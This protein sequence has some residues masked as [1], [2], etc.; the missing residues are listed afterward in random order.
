VPGSPPGAIER[1]RARRL[2]GVARAGAGAQGRL[3]GPAVNRCETEAAR[4]LLMTLGMSWS[5]RTQHAVTRRSAALR[6]EFHE[7]FAVSDLLEPFELAAL[8]RMLG[9][10]DEVRKQVLELLRE[11][12]VDV[13]ELD[14]EVIGGR[15]SLRGSVDDPLTML[16][17]E[18]L[19]WLHPRVQQCHNALKVAPR[20]HYSSLMML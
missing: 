19:A 1:R 20:P 2:S 5:R 17:V 14:V 3:A 15:V 18:D 4:A 9:G 10:D 13:D 8:E 11:H 12:D 7:H 16:L 6:A